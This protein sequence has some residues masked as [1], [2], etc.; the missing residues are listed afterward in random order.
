MRTNIRISKYFE[1]WKQL[2]CEP[3][4]GL[5]YGIGLINR[6]F[7]KIMMILSFRFLLRALDWSTI[8]LVNFKFWYFLSFWFLLRAFD[9]ST[10]Y[11]VY[12]LLFSD[13]QTNN[14]FLVTMGIF[15]SVAIMMLIYA[16]YQCTFSYFSQ[17]DF[18]IISSKILKVSIVDAIGVYIH[19]P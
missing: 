18:L 2:F 7:S 4:F 9:W 1:W 10:T 6:L 16:D 5:S 3:W 11:Q 19:V 13:T 15:T 17:S 14:R 12:A 8:Y